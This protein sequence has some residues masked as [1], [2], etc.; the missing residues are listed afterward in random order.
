MMPVILYECVLG[1]NG[2]RVW[3]FY[4]IS[5]TPTTADLSKMESSDDI[6]ELREIAD[7]CQGNIN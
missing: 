5:A 3:L 2:I 7:S 6:A 1:R 4:P